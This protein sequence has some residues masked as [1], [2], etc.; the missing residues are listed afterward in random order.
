MSLLPSQT[1]I[2]LDTYFFLRG[3]GQS[4]NVSSL[5]ANTI[6]TNSI[7]ASQMSTNTLDAESINNSTINTLHVDLDGQ[8][9]TATPTELLLNGVPLATL[10]S[11]SS[12]ADWSLD[13]AISTVQMAGNNI[14]QA[15]AI[16]TGSIVGGSAFFTN[17]M[18]INSMFLSTYTSTISSYV[19][20]ADQ[21]FYSTIST[22]TLTG[23]NV[24]PSTLWGQ[25]SSYYQDLVSSISSLVSDNIICST[26]TATDRISTP[27]LFV[28]SINGAEFTSTSINVEVAGVSSLVANTVSSIGAE[29]RTALVST[30]QFNPSFSPNLDVNLGLGSL[31]GNLAGAASGALGVLVGGA[32][33]GTGIAALSQSRQTNY[34]NASTFELVNGTTQLQISTLA[35]P[36]TTIYRFVNSASPST[37][38][39][40]V[41]VS[42]VTGP[43]DY[44]RSMSDPLN[45]VS[46]PNSTIQS[47]GQWVK[48]P[49]APV[50]STVSTF[51]DIYTSSLQ[52][53]TINFPG[54][55]QLKRGV[56]FGG[57][58]GVSTL[59]LFWTGQAPPL[60]ADLRLGALIISGSDV[61]GINYSK[62]VLIQNANNGQ[63]LTVYG[64]AGTSPS[65]VAF[66]SD[67][68]AVPPT[69]STFQ[70]LGTSSFTA[71]TISMPA[72]ATIEVG[73]GPGS[74]VLLSGSSL[75]LY[76]GSVAASS[77][78]VDN[79]QGYSGNIINM[80][81]QNLYLTG[82]GRIYAGE[83]SVSSLT[84]ST[85]NG[86]IP[87]TTANPPTVFDTSTILVSS[88]GSIG[89]TS[90][91]TIVP[92][93]LS[94]FNIDSI[95][96]F[97][98]VGS[99]FN[100]QA[101][102]SATL[103]AELLV[104]STAAGGNGLF[105]LAAGG[106]GNLNASTINVSTNQMC[107]NTIST[108]QITASSLTLTAPNAVS[109]ATIFMTSAGGTQSQPTQRFRVGADL[110]LGNANDIWVRNARLGAGN[111]GTGA[112]LILY[113]PAN[114]QAFVNWN[115]QD[116]A[117][118]TSIQ[119]KGLTNY[120]YLLD[121][122]VNPPLFSTVNAGTS[123]AM[124]AW[125]PS[126]LT[127]TIG[128]STISVIPN[129]IFVA[130]GASL[131]SQ[132]VT[133]ANTPLA[134]D[135]G[136]ASVNIGGYTFAASTLTVPVAGTYEFSPSIQFNT[137][138]GGSQVVDFWFTKNGADLP[139]SA[140]RVNVANNAQTV[141]TVI[142]YDTAAAGDK[143]GMK[144]AS[145]DANM[146][147]GFFQ[148]TVTTPYT[149]PAIPSV[150]F[151][152]QRVA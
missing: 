24:E 65:T 116:R 59:E 70:T 104:D 148:S 147:A 133:A 73:S 119:S 64:P 7:T 30:L 105:R 25:P 78:L 101:Q 43:G 8:I 90:S 9:L 117:L 42:T 94:F 49:D 151:N 141:G 118:R 91:I 140:T 92:N 143:Y 102:S 86:G 28:S 21:G 60:D 29:L 110:D 36:Q 66:L 127:S 22:G 81:G 109:T 122:F 67:I 107:V 71:S 14:D 152:A 95:G 130:A 124:M 12:I 113:D 34:I 87:F 51:S 99:K 63:R 58:G 77:T 62:D 111:T 125:F 53:S 120:G 100:L 38:G 126:S 149:R 55:T 26:L 4:L 69:A 54:D 52:T 136:S 50:V 97:T 16:S 98:E 35:S 61:G 5:N 19:N 75:T 44:I 15:G 37:P 146:Q 20:T 57:S 135:L 84:V 45:T 17:L 1:N 85:L 40:E 41:F 128:Y 6:S 121:T 137:T 33:L 103:V 89:N 96:R 74:Q 47:F 2:N 31:F 132:Q 79:I 112:E 138:T 131:S 11:L 145:A 13:P 83:G 142:L 115:T 76:G 134:L 39:E 114:Q 68:P 144:I 3:S 150:I 48:L 72:G 27:Q 32:A 82:P 46:S 129:P 23:G 10:S 139:N 93:A 18:A 80:P 56:G 123:T 108:S 88:I 106:V